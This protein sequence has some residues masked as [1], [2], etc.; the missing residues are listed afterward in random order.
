M[1]SIFLRTCLATAALAAACS[2]TDPDRQ[3]REPGFLEYYASPVEVTV[4]ET[5][6]AGEPFTVR[7]VTR[8]GGCTS[9]GDTEVAVSGATAD[10]S[11]YDLRAEGPNIACPDILR[12]LPHEVTVRFDTPGTATVRVHGRREPGLETITV[13][14]TVTV[15]PAG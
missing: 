6:R 14:R 1:R 10:V 12:A 9:A 15:Q 7:A 13:T 3:V 11:P 8:G 5:V 4:P 2:P